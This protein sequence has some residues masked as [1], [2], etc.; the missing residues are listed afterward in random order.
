MA[1][2]KLIKQPKKSEVAE[3]KPVEDVSERPR[4]EGEKD[5]FHEPK[6]K[7]FKNN[8]DKGMK[9]KLIDGNKFKW[10]TVRTG[11]VVSIPRKLALAN[12]LV[13]VE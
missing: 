6:V 8:S 3:A 12:K 11:E 4:E 1:K 2:D 10:I 13:E 7:Q 5:T 9:I